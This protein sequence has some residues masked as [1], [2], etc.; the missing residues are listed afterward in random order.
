MSSVEV[1]YNNIG[2]IFSNNYQFSMT[3]YGKNK[4]AVR[5]RTERFN[6]VV[7]DGDKRGIKRKFYEDKH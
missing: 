5:V 1:C 2:D 3:N 4:Y 7:N 6:F